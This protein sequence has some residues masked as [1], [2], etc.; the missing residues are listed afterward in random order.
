MAV[1]KAYN[2]R[3]T[4]LLYTTDGLT[5]N[6]VPQIKRFEPDSSKQAMADQTNLTSPGDFTQPYPTLI[7]AGYVDVMCVL[8]PQDPAYLLLG[9]AHGRKMLLGW[10]VILVDGCVFGFQAYV[11]EFKP[12]SV[13]VYKTLTYSMRLR[14]AGGIE[15]PISTFAPS[16][17][18]AGT[19]SAIQ[20]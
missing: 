16:V 10:R 7:D 17:F 3:G 9:E 2:G 1:P 19:F 4:A 8:N 13:N 15:S 14:I 20:I 11:A 5:Y 18:A 12:F 6:P